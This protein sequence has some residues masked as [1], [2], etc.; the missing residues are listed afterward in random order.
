M[1]FRPSKLRNATIP[2]GSS[3]TG[4]LRPR[5]QRRRQPQQLK[6]R[7]PPF[8]LPLRSGRYHARS[9]F[10]SFHVRR[11]NQ[12]SPAVGF[13]LLVEPTIMSEPPVGVEPVQS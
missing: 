3:S 8:P 7:R 6:S 9:D 13:W 4:R 12:V 5:P 1:R 10:I 11:S 2:I